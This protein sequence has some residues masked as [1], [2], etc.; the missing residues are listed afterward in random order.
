MTDEVVT[1][2]Q[3]MVRIPSINPQTRAEVAPP[4]GEAQLAAFVFDWLDACGLKPQRQEIA[5]GRQNVFVR[6]GGTDPSKTLLFSS[7]MDTVDV[8]DMTV[9]PFGGELRDGRLYG[10]GACDTKGSLA[11]MMIALR[12]RLREGALPCNIVFLASCGEEFDLLGTKHFAMHPDIKPSG[13]VFGEP[14]GLAVHTAHR[15]VVRLRL[16]TRG[17]SAHSSRPA[18]GVNAIYPMARII[19][20]IETFADGLATVPAHPQLGHESIAVT[21]VQGGQQVNVV[22][23][24][25]EAQVDWRVLP[26]RTI[27]ACRDELHRVLQ[28][29]PSEEVTLEGVTYYAPMYT[30]AGSP[31]CVRLLDAA[32]QTA[33]VRCTAVCSGATDASAFADCRIPTLIMGPGDMSRAHTQDEYVDTAELEDGLAVYTRFLNGD[34]GI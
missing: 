32:E 29:S 9:D 30:D 22:P 1:L 33:A 7:H 16:T 20:A 8:Q 23:D 34:W 4:Y 17:K 12:D 21:I 24:R 18:N 26:G 27:Q 10:R 25:C 3:Q 2:T 14:T 13:A 28:E 11:A 31:L 6:A 5:P 19:T 15:G